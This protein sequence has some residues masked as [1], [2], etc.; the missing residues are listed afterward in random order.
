MAR[1][2][3]TPVYSATTKMVCVGRCGLIRI[4]FLCG[5]TSGGQG[6]S[7]CTCDW[8]VENGRSKQ[9]GLIEPTLTLLVS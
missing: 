1:S 4:A 5:G 3:T 9:F 7:V 6:Q 8:V 2:G